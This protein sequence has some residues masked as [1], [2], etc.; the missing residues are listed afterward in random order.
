MSEVVNSHNEWDPLEEIIVGILEGSSNN[1]QLEVGQIATVPRELYEHA[2][3]L[4]ARQFAWATGKSKRATSQSEHYE[5]AQRD[6]DEFVHLLEAEGV[7]VRR[8]DPVD[9]ARAYSTLDWTSLSGSAQSVPRDVLIVIGN[10]I[11]EAPMSWRSRYFEFRS[12]RTLVREYFRQGAG[13]TAAPKPQMTDELYDYEYRRGEGWVTT[14]VEPV[15][16][17]A[18]IARFGRDI[19]VQ[20]S[21]V[22]NEAGIEWLRRHLSPT[23]NLHAVEF[24]DERAM[25]ID[26]TFVPLAPGKLLVNPDRPIRKLPE[27]FKKAGWEV[28]EAPRTT[29]PPKPHEGNPYRWLHM[30]ML[31]L[32]DKRVIVEKN[33][34]PLI[35]AL[36]SWGFTPIPCSF[37]AFYPFGGSFHCAT[38]DVRRRGSLQSYF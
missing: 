21:H 33:E 34:E 18:D 6:L 2:G 14:E 9:Q 25:H 19:F 29:L 32:D 27:M 31:S 24:S 22:T 38:C 17:A 12:Y 28:L 7:K 13:W 3:E 11:I 4:G 20:R 37:R 10:E 26:A 23:Y 16:D 36:K 15:F 8:P 1:A 35:Q 30:N 5:A